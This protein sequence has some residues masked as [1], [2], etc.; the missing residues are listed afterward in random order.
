M[1]RAMV[2]YW[3]V[4]LGWYMLHENACY[5][6]SVFHDWDASQAKSVWWNTAWLM[7]FLIFVSDQRCTSSVKHLPGYVVCHHSQG[8]YRYR[9]SRRKSKYQAIAQ[10]ISASQW[11]MYSESSLDEFPVFIFLPASSVVALSVKHSTHLFQILLGSKD[12]RICV[13]NSTYF[14]QSV[15]VFRELP[16][17]WII[18]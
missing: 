2:Q 12:L 7:Q 11:Q 15:K 8:L 13:F 9:G 5:S 1:R 17:G 3:S 14:L 4:P 10:G 16:V 18:T 6:L